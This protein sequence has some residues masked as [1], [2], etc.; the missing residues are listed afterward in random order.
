MLVYRVRVKLGETAARLTVSA[1]VSSKTLESIHTRQFL[2]LKNTHI[3][4]KTVKN[5]F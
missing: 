4:I 1:F 2:N 5:N 3:I